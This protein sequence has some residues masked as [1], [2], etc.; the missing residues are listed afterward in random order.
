VYAFYHANK[1]TEETEQCR[2]AQRQVYTRRIVVET[3]EEAEC[4]RSVQRQAH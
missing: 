1:T 3:I 2:T 4:R